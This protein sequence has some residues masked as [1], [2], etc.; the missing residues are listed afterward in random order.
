AIRAIAPDPISAAPKITAPQPERGA[1]LRGGLVSVVVA[2]TPPFR[3][4]CLATAG[5]RNMSREG[6]VPFRRGQ[7]MLPVGAGLGA[8]DH[9]RGER[10]ELPDRDPERHD[11]L[12]VAPD[13]IQE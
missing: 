11:V 5:R 7:A 2:I 1:L 9:V 3:V 8:A 12:R 13:P 4:E 10:A 6:T